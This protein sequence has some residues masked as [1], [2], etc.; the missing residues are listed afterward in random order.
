MALQRHY[1]SS[2]NVSVKPMSCNINIV[3]YMC[4][5]DIERTHVQCAKVEHDVTR[6][7]TQNIASRITSLV[8]YTL[9]RYMYLSPPSSTSVPLAH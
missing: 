3:I 2:N 9:A 5:M 6:V 1:P 4:N 8:A 7:L